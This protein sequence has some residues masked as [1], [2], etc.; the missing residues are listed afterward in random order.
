MVDKARPLP[1]ITDDTKP[2]W[3]AAGRGVLVVQKC[4]ACGVFQ[5]YPRP[6][7]IKC[8]SEEIDWVETGGAGTL[9]TYTINHKA[10]DPSFAD[11]TPYAV[12]IVELDE[13]PRLLT[14]IVD[15]PLESVRIGARVRVC[16]ERI[17]EEVVLPQF[18]IAG[19]PGS[20]A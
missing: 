17:S 2:Y 9:Y 5:F 10:A 12:A 3:D 6:F 4:R 11:R 15:S 18:K 19:A 16:F 8:L 13:G 14:N 1:G 20:G 7:C